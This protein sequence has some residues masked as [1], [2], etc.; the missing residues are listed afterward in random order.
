M[1]KWVV[2]CIVIMMLLFSQKMRGQS[3]TQTYID[4]CDSKVYVVSFP[5]TNTGVMVIIRGTSKVFTYSQF[6]SGEV[7]SWINSIF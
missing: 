4:P 1:N 2:S 6:Q 3:I 7:T 5:I